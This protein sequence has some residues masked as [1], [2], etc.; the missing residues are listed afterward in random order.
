MRVDNVIVLPLAGLWR[1]LMHFERGQ[2]E[3]CPRGY[4][5]VGVFR[6]STGAVLLRWFMF[7]AVLCPFRVTMIVIVS[8]NVLCSCR[9]C[10]CLNMICFIL[11][12]KGEYSSL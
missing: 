3:Q 1:S 9:E 11:L 7:C 2:T 8:M 10:Q 6:E 5:P 12:A 4:C